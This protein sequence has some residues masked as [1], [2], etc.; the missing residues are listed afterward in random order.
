MSSLK[1]GSFLNGSLKPMRK[2]EQRFLRVDVDD[3][4]IAGA[5]GFCKI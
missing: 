2:G 4:E 3:F 5:K 1:K